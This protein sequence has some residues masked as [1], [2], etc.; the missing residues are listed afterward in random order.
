M[1]DIARETGLTLGTVSR[2]LNTSGKYSIA[3]E[4]RERVQKAAEVL[5]YRPNLL[6][7]A[8][9]AGAS[10]LVLLMSPNPFSSYYTEVGR[11]LAENLGQSGLTV[12]NAKNPSLENAELP[13]DDWLYGVDGIVINDYGPGA[14]RYVLEAIRLKIPVVG[15]GAAEVPGADRIF[16]DLYKPARELVKHLVDQGCK[17]VAYLCDAGIPDDDTR[18]KAYLSAMEDAGQEPCF[19]PSQHQTKA[20]GRASVVRSVAQG[21][22][23]DGLFCYNDDL[24]IGAYRGLT[25][26]GLEVPAQVALAGCDGIDET[27]YHYRPITTIG[28]PMEEMCAWACETLLMRMAGDDGPLRLKEANATLMI[29]GSSTRLG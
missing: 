27:Q 2:A 5:G 22:S 8:L 12:I 1:A 23:F 3:A 9:A 6:G 17:R 18:T 4:T 29:R 15:I 16:A 25:D 19:I 26:L 11:Y 13:L 14:E 21:A 7:R 10:K 24:A 20:D 28:F